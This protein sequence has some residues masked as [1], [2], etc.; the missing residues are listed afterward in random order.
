MFEDVDL[1]VGMSHGVGRTDVKDGSGIL[2]G[3]F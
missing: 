2:H 3:T 1:E